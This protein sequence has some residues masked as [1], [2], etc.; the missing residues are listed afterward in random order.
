M[1]GFLYSYK[2]HDV[3]KAIVS[4][5][6]LEC[7]GKGI[8]VQNT[9][10]LKWFN[11]ESTGIGNIGFHNVKMNFEDAKKYCASL[12]SH[13]IEFSTQAQYDFLKQKVVTIHSKVWTNMGFGPVWWLGLEYRSDGNWYWIHSNTIC[14]FGNCWGH[15]G[16][17]FSKYGVVS[18][19]RMVLKIYKYVN[20][21][22][23]NDEKE[24]DLFCPICQIEI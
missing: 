2:K 18:E 20:E 22:F 6:P 14:K 13:L 15:D 7:K 5:G 24:T 10:N 12:N 4:I 11:G 19:H 16:K 21:V 17:G 1:T 8:G 23:V 9:T 3:Q